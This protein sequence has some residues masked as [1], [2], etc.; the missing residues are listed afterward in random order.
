MSY[1]FTLQCGCTVYVACHPETRVAHTR[2]IEK[3]GAQCLERRHEV[4]ARLYLW[5]LLPSREGEL[6]AV[7]DIAR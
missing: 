5:E 2:I 6:K 1:T 7:G 3:R 4:G